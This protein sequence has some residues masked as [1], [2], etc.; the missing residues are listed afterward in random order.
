MTR[1]SF[2][3]ASALVFAAGSPSAGQMQKTAA[4][5]VTAPR[6]TVDM[7][8]P[9]PMPNHWILGSVTGV[10][11]DSHDHI[12]VLHVPDYFTVRTELGVG[13]TG[14]SGECCFAA[15]PVLEF[16]AAGNLVGHWGGPGDGYTWPT[17]PRG[18]AVDKD[19]NVWIG[20]SG[21][22]DT[23]ILK[24]SHDGKFIAQ[25]GRSAAAPAAAPAA[26][27]A[28]DTAY[29]GVSN[30]GGGAGRGA[31]GGR[32]G[33]GRRGG[34][35]GPVIPPNS[36]SMDAFGGVAAI[37]FDPSG[38]DAFVADG[39]RNHRVAVVDMSTGAIKRFWGANG[40][41]P[42]DEAGSPSQF[43]TVAC[44]APSKDGLVYVCDRANDRLQV[45]RKDG[46][47]VTEKKI[48]PETRGEGAVWDV[49]FSSD[50]QQKYLFVADGL[51]QKIWILDRKSLD[52]LAAF[53]D[54]GR[55][56]GQFY[57]VTSIATDSRGNLYTGEFYEGKR[58]Q[59][60]DFKGVG[61]AKVDAGTVWPAKGGS[62]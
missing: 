15:P 56:P 16:D 46:S 21:G 17:Q 29:A 43:H 24:F 41:A 27:A 2:V 61:A 58:V 18:I 52:V 50:P 55:Q 25:I 47:F 44:A 32:G 30:R 26:A 42:T 3:V 5:S 8:W 51:N 9:K 4:K 13:P 35:A 1:A 6:F 31:A 60:F 19:G 14:P 53:G 10:T 11:V 7:L 12:W 34:A 39:Y 22:N 33:R 62:K 49:A 54:G 38:N 57:G 28:P 40:Q 37:G 20:G 23:D 45:F 48:A 36:T 59:K